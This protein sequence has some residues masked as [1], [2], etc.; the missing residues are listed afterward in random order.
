MPSLSPS[1]SPAPLDPT[2]HAKAKP[3]AVFAL[4]PAAQD[5]VYGAEDRRTLAEFVEIEDLVLTPEN[6]RS[7]RDVLH[8]AEFVFSG[9]KS[10]VYDAEFLAA[11]PQLRAIFYAAGSIRYCATEAF[12]AK[13]IPICSA[14]AANAVPVAEYTVSVSVLALK[15]FWRRAALARQ[16]EGWGDHTRPIPGAFRATIGLVSFGMI[17]RK[18]AEMFAAYDVRVLV[19]CPY[20]DETEAMTRGVQRVSLNQLFSESDVVSVHTPV[21][22]ETI[23]MVHGGLVRT[24]KPDATLINTSRGV[25]LD[26]ASVIEALRSRPDLT[27]VLDVT[28]PEP[29]AASDPLFSLPNIIVTPHI[30]G[31][32]GGECQRLGSYMV[33][34]LR[35]FLAGQ[36]LRWRITH[37][38]SL[39]MA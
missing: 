30:A 7:H 35:R 10:P 5:I 20:L 19:Y 27:V 22:P 37:E 26:Q 23:N 3:R 25:I 18:V 12:W 1:L 8:E 14:Y 15:Q 6:W 17:A 38:M 34:E 28:H 9:W 33:D 13:G 31:S 24:M 39:R 29:P 16:G 11:T 2:A 36:E 32:L 4:D 21:L